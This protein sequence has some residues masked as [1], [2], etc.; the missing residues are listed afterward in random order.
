MTIELDF[1]AGRFR[2]SEK[3]ADSALGWAPL[4]ERGMIETRLRI[5]EE[6]MPIHIDSGNA[7]GRGLKGARSRI[8]M[9]RKRWHLSYA[10]N[11]VPVI[12]EPSS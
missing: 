12:G 11:A 4:N 7:G 8:D 9:P 1:P 3:T 5:G 2:L 6:T 10:D